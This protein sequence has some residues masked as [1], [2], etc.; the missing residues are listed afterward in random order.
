VQRRVAAYLQ[1]MANIEPDVVD[2]TVDEI[3]PV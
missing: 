3:G 2:V 1:Q